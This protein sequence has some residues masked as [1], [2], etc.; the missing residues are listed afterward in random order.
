MIRIGLLYILLL[1]LT[2]DHDHV[3]LSNFV[4]HRSPIFQMHN[5]TPASWKR[6]RAG[7]HHDD[8]FATVVITTTFYLRRP[9]KAILTFIWS[10]YAM[11]ILS[12]FTAY[13]Y[14]IGKNDHG[15]GD[16]Q[17]SFYSIR[18]HNVVTTIEYRTLDH[19]SSTVPANSC[20]TISK[21]YFRPWIRQHWVM[22][23]QIGRTI[24]N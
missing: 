11:Q 10:C 15:G 17:L 22:T 1:W 4:L 3:I 9:L 5:I 12:G 18:A 21:C 24:L 8:I 20:V 2:H 19:L 14:Q 23:F 13:I 7:Q 16:R 6:C